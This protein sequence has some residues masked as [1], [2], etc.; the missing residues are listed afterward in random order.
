MCNGELGSD[1]YT[2]LEPPD[3]K[4]TSAGTVSVSGE[5]NGE[6]SWL[7]VPGI[8]TGEPTG[9]ILAGTPAGDIST[10]VGIDNGTAVGPDNDGDSEAT[11]NIV[12]GVS[13]RSPMASSPAG[14]F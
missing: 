2:V 7:K 3:G 9:E 6:V 4:G 12:I 14:M 5:S 10:S 13:E 1:P 11:I 8:V